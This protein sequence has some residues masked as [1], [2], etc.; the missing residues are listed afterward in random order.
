[1][2]LEHFLT[3]HTKINSKWFK[4]L[5]IIPENYKTL[6]KDSKR[7]LIDGEIYHVH[8]SEESI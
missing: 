8:G 1:M 7:T 6:V 5:N 2:K 3:P 4:D